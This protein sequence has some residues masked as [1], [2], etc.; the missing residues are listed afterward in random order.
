V[1]LIDG[2]FSSLV[3]NAR[4]NGE[5]AGSKM[6]LPDKGLACHQEREGGVA[7]E[8]TGPSVVRAV[9][10]LSHHVEVIS[11]THAPFPVVVPEKMA[12][13]VVEFARI[14]FSLRGLRSIDAV[15]VCGIG[16]VK[17]VDALTRSEA[18]IIV[19]GGSIFTEMSHRHGKKLTSLL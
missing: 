7:N 5:S 10:V 11:T 4:Q 3:S 8:S 15:N 1:H 2:G 14:T 18:E 17:M 12:N 9:K 6:K 13:R 19:A 16:D